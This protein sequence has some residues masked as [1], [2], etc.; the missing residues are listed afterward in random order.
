MATAAISKKVMLEVEPRE[1]TGST[2]GRRLRRQGRVPGNLY[3]LDRPAFKVS[4]DPR[5]IDELLRLGSGVNTVFQLSL[6]GQDKT[7]EAMI[8]ELQRDPVTGQPVHVDF[9]RVDPTKRVQISV[10]VHLVGTPEGVKNEGGIID[11]VNRVVQVSCLPT[12]IPEHFDVDVTELHVNQHVS[13]SDLT[14]GVGVTLLDDPDQILAVVVAPRVEEVAASEEAVAAEGEPE[15][16]AAAPAEG[17]GA[18]E[19]EKKKEG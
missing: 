1:S 12:H 7:R 17:E 18:G 2:A 16:G 4:V 6:V 11:F 13:V 14:T 19:T 15:G 9:I 5:R 10:P 3:G 8:K